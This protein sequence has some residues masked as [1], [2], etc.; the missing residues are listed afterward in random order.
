[1]T[2]VR[3]KGGDMFKVLIKHLHLSEQVWIRKWEAAQTG[4][5]LGRGSLYQQVLQV[6]PG[7]LGMGASLQEAALYS[8]SGEV[9]RGSNMLLTG[10]LTFNKPT[11]E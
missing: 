11:E 5:T 4:L 9:R 7:L 3:N 1:M 6:L 8:A 10:L 2:K